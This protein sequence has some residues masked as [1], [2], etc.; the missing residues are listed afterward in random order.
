[1]FVVSVLIVVLFVV[2]ES[3]RLIDLVFLMVLLLLIGMLSDLF[4]LFLLV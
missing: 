4:V 3:S 1:M 2:W